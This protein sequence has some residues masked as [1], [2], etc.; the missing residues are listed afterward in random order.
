MRVIAHRGRSG[1]EPENSLATFQ[2]AERRGIEGVE[3]D[4]RQTSDGVLAV[5]HD[6]EL[7]G[8]TV[9]A[10]DYR[11]LA[12]AG[13][14]CTLSEALAALPPRCLVD[15]EV[16]VDDIE[17][18][19]LSEIRAG[20][21]HCDLV[22]TSFSMLTVTRLKALQPGLRAGLLV[23]ASDVDGT[24]AEDLL[25][26]LR[27][28]QADF[29]AAEGPLI[30]RP[31]LAD[32]GAAHLPVWAWT[33]NSARMLARLDALGVEAVITDEPLSAMHLRDIATRGR[34]RER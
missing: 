28:C 31:L 18:A 20:R 22:I 12:G 14:L 7:A 1:R 3:L 27:A 34:R 11:E 19:V 8:L 9:A 25:P 33:V 21:P 6:A 26:R 5:C 15:I 23:S 10:S 32:M 4:V 17:A 2:A 24:P 29:I 16:K 30:T 13:D